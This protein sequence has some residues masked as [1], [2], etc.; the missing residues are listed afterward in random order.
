MIIDFHTHIF[1]DHVAPNAIPHLEKEGGV[2]AY[3]NGTRT[4]LLASMATHGIDAS[5]V[6]SIATK[7]AQ[8]KS[9][10]EW[11]QT[12]QSDRLIPFASIHPDDPNCLAQ[13]C[14]I[15]EMGLKGIKMHPYY[16][17]FFLND[18]KMLPIFKLVS[19]LQLILLMHTGYDIAFPKIRRADP[20][21]ILQAHSLFPNVKLVTSHLGA[22]NQWDEVRALLVGRPLYMDI[23]FS[24]QLLDKQT[25]RDII[26]NHPR[27]YILFGSD[28]PWEDQGKSL[29]MLE[30]L[31]LDAELLK[32]IQGTNAQQLLQ[33]P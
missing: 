1:P 32:N 31:E 21:K 19:D 24:L 26:C 2:K 29:E 17:D 13:L 11:S 16:Q 6:C 20:E 3:L 25:A 18:K 10:L 9:I 23:S 33:A 28:S 4:D 27:E 12:L 14:Q 15:K 8:F 30:A 7:P 5:V 22:W